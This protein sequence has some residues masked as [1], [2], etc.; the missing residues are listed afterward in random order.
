MFYRIGLLALATLGIAACAETG[1][2]I[3]GSRSSDSLSPFYAPSL[4]SYEAQDGRFP[5]VIRGNPFAGV[6][7]VQLEQSIHRNTRTPAWAPRAQFVR[8]E[9]AENGEGLRLVVIFNPVQTLDFRAMCGDLSSIGTTGPA[10]QSTI[11]M[12][13]CD[14]RQ[15]M[16][17]VVYRT[18]P[19]PDE[20]SAAFIGAVNNA[21]ARTLPFVDV[22]RENF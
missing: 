15:T 8:D 1:S 16:S 20:Q 3:V 10:N 19:A 18:G 9:R 21:A 22:A 5:M 7:Q 13:F 11:R 17:D 2:G 12:A 6:P 4:V 14:G